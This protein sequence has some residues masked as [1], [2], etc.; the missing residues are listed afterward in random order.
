MTIATTDA[1]RS[2]STHFELADELTAT[3]P[4]EY[5]GRRRDEV[6]LLVAGADGIEQATFRELAR[7]LAPGDLV[8]VNTSATIA[9][10]VDAR[11]LS[12]MDANTGTNTGTNTGIRPSSPRPAV[13]H[14][15]TQLDDGDVVIE[16]R[17]APAARRPILDARPGDHVELPTGPHLLLLAPYPDPSRPTGSTRLWRAH[18][19]PAATLSELAGPTAR[20]IAYGYLSRRWPLRDYQTIFGRDPGSAEM[21]SAG[22]PFTGRVLADLAARGVRV[23]P[24]TLHTGVSSQD[25]GEGPQAERYSVPAATAQL[26]TDTRRA[27]GRVVAVGTTVTR[28]LESATSA[29]RVTRAATGWTSLVI[30][31]D[32]P[33]RVVSG[34]VTGWHD[35]Q[36]SHLMLVEAIAGAELTQRAYDA[37]VAARYRWHE[38][39]DSCLLLP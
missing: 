22:R 32:R 23:A 38:F 39:G 3:E 1:G 37:A 7:F 34:L 12:G 4:P 27:G 21:P 16:L 10:E 17:E 9:A 26:V 14:L 15:A 28:A 8:V 18:P 35:P 36:A 5:R 31:P 20:P 24:I 2:P 19:Q 13:L 25:A 11:L 29:D 30:G 33:I 6:R